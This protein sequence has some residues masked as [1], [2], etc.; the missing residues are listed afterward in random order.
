MG[1]ERDYLS[2]TKRYPRLA[3]TPEFSKVWHYVPAADQYSVWNSAFSLFSNLSF[4]GVQIVLNWAKENLN[5]SL[6]TPV[7][8]A[9]YW[10]CIIVH[11]YCYICFPS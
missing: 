7:R 9:F 4:T 8:Y 5:L 6:H 1:D 3:I 11:T 10:E 2:L